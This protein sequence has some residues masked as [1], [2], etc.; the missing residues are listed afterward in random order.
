M[1][2]QTKLNAF[3]SL[4]GTFA[5]NLDYSFEYPRMVHDRLIYLHQ[6]RNFHEFN[7]SKVF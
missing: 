2:S 3:H 7:L 5:K 6:L 1:N 4:R